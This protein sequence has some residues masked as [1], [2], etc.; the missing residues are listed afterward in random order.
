M[1]RARS[2]TIR[3][4]AHE[5]RVSVASASRALNGADGVT[6]AMRERVLSAARRLRYVPHSG[7]RILSTRRTNTFGVILPDLYGEFFSEIIRGADTAARAH[8]KHLLLSSSHDGADAVAEVIRSMRGRV[9]GLLVM[10]PHIDAQL[11]ADSLADDLPMV[12]LNTEV[13]GGRHPCFRVDNYAG[14]FAAA[15]HLAERARLVAHIAGPLNNSEAEERCRGWRDALGE[16]A[17]PLLQGDFTEESGFLAGQDLARMSPRPDAVF[18]ANDT[19]AVGCLAALAEAGIAVPDAMAVAGFDDIPIARLMRPSLT[20]VSARIADL[21]RRALERL[22]RL[23]DTPDTLNDL[24]E[25][26]RPEVIVRG[27]SRVDPQSRHSNGEQ[28]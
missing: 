25:T 22:A 26:V 28:G 11:L 7:A 20:T 14:A 19:M 16:T 2:I 24:L 27:S 9:D 10:S 21:S 12:L 18:A 4:V 6:E 17:G 1:R 15:R 13:E 5:A 8:G 3:D 23:V